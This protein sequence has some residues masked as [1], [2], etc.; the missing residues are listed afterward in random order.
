MTDISGVPAVLRAR[1]IFVNLPVRDLD[2]SVAFF[3]HLG[4]GFDPASTDDRATAMIVN[5][6]AFVMLL[7]EDYFSTFTR[8]PVPTTRETVVAL[9]AESP[10]EVDDLVMRALTAGGSPAQDRI[11]DGP[12]HGWSFLDPDGH[13]W[14]LIHLDLNGT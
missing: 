4:F 3:T 10:Q 5:D 12:F 2:R 14:E 6:G 9:S 11:V 8:Q 7:V 1:K 13:Q